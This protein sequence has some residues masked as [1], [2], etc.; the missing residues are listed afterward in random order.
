AVL[1]IMVLG[2][3]GGGALCT[4]VVLFPGY[5]GQ[6]RWYVL[7]LMFVYVPLVLERTAMRNVLMIE[8]RAFKL[9]IMRVSCACLTIL[10]I[11]VFYLFGALEPGH[12]II[13]FVFGASLGFFLGYGWSGEYINFTARPTVATAKRLLFSGLKL[14]L[15]DLMVIVR[16]QFSIFLVKFLFDDFSNVGYF[17]TGQRI[18][19]LVIISGQAVLP[20]LFSTWANFPREH[21]ARHVEKVLRFASTISISFILVTLL[22]LKWAIVFLYGEEFLPAVPLAMLL[23][24][25]TLIYMLSNILMQLL[26]SRGF[27]CLSATM[28]LVSIIINAIASWLLIPSMGIIG[29]AIGFLIG[30]IFL[31]LLV[32]AVAKIKYKLRLAHCF[33]LRKQDVR[34]IA[35]FFAAR[36]TNVPEP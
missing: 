27:P 15:V 24:P 9:G 3:L 25:G 21:L 36:K 31:F 11:M 8:I 33:I 10:L 2:I 16:S 5:F 18:T 26:S 1:L 4:T 7:A 14:N 35:V 20:L 17:S 28:L 12:A 19:V 30:D 6:V 22:V 34:Q 32:G 23:I 29:A 13:C